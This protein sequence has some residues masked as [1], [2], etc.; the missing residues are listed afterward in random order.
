MEAG[1]SPR[2][3]RPNLTLLLDMTASFG[4]GCVAFAAAAAAAATT[5]ASL[6]RYL[7]PSATTNCNNEI[8]CFLAVLSGCLL[9]VCC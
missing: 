9:S 2:E 4:A 8:E 1:D 6:V 7:P 3:G 5:T